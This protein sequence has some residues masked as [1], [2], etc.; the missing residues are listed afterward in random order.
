MIFSSDQDSGKSLTN[1]CASSARQNE[2]WPSRSDVFPESKSFEKRWNWQ[3]LLTLRIDSWSEVSWEWKLL[4]AVCNWFLFLNY[5]FSWSTWCGN[6]KGKFLFSNFLKPTLGTWQQSP[7]R[8]F[9]I[10]IFIVHYS[11]VEKVKISFSTSRLPSTSQPWFQI[12]FWNHDWTIFLLR[13]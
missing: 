2:H 8:N 11:T 6:V 1:L 5:P 10:D 3:N 13:S 7:S 4:V 12:S 9:T